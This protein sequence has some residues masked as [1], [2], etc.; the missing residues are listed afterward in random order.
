MNYSNMPF[1]IKIS[2]ILFFCFGL[3][4]SCK[5]TS[6]PTDSGLTV[7]QRDTLLIKDSIQTESFPTQA[8]FVFNLQGAIN[9]KYSITM[10]L[11]SINSEIEGEYRYDTQS[12]S[13]EL[14][15]KFQGNS[16]YLTNGIV[17]GKDFIT[18]EFFEGTIANN[19]IEGMWNSPIRKKTFPF[20]LK[21]LQG[22]SLRSNFVVLTNARL[23]SESLWEIT[24]IRIY[25][26]KG[27][28]IQEFPLDLILQKNLFYWMDVNKD[29]Y[30][31]IQFK[32]MTG[33]VNLI[34]NSD[35]KHFIQE[36]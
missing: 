26:D 35:T 19:T 29:G 33:L 16:I 8:C 13:L 34:F 20:K 18:S 17:K 14:Q 22:E 25:S 7:P 6:T 28:F 11:K 2:K 10:V 36:K 27:E 12:G 1:R 3:L 21:T 24:Y 30:L 15:G 9:E 32:T 23:N 5:Q 4:L 31:D